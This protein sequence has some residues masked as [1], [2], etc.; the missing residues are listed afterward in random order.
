MSG[1]IESAMTGSFG[2]GLRFARYLLVGAASAI[3]ATAG[4]QA[5]D[6]ESV[7]SAEFV[8]VCT[9]Y[10]AGF[11]YVPGTDTCLKVGGYLRA[12]VGL[13]R[14]G[15]EVAI[16]APDRLTGSLGG[17]FDRV[18]TNYFSFR[19]RGLL[20]ADVRTQTEYGRQRSY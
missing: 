14:D 20:S 16:G 4:A 7:K 1:R 6:S 12:Q 3:I 18:D 9:L 5:A 11:W 15:N 10:G 2:S 13:N 8:K 19:S 17:R